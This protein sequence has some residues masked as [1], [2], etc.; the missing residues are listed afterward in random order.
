M[1]TIPIDHFLDSDEGAHGA[2]K[3]MV[4]WRRLVADGRAARAAAD[5]GSWRI[6]DL[7]LL[8]ERRYATG[9]LKRFAQ[10]IGESHG[11]VRRFRWVA[12][13]YDAAAR[14]RFADLSFSHF[15]TVA[16]LDDRMLWLERASRGSWSVDR[17]TDQSRFGAGKTGDDRLVRP[18]ATAARSLERLIENADDREFARAA[19][20]GLAEAVDELAGQIE[21]LRARL[22]RADRRRRR[23]S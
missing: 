1:R 3:S 8:V 23:A 2:G 17:L 19:R 14:A 12:G 21:R 10:E 13:A 9:A 15:Q 7:A 5:G 16:S 18:V 6:G 20:A 4:D 22:R 11:S